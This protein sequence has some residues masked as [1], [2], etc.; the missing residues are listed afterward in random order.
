MKEVYITHETLGSDGEKLLCDNME[1][2][3]KFY[4]GPLEADDDMMRQTLA[5][6][7]CT[8]SLFPVYLTFEPLTGMENDLEKLFKNNKIDYSLRYE[9]LKNK[10]F[11]V[12]K[13]TIKECSS[14]IFVLHETFW[15]A[16]CNIFYALSFS[17]NIVYKPVNGKSW[18]G[19]EKTWIWPH[20][21]MNGTSTIMEIWNDGDGFNLYT[22]EPR[23]STL[24]KLASLFP[25]ETPIVKNA[26]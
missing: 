8:K 21:N 24:E 26:E 1:K 22:T 10:R 15:V 7:I 5:D 6:F 13:L 19:R 9:G 14:L 18:L 20:F 12:F 25:S 2:V 16:T 4:I 23:F 11:P 3:L 17:D